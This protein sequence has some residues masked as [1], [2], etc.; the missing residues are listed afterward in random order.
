M[1]NHRV[2]LFC[3]KF[4][5]LD[6]K[7][8]K[9]TTLMVNRATFKDTSKKFRVKTRRK[10]LFNKIIRW[11]TGVPCNRERACFTDEHQQRDWYC[12]TS[13]QLWAF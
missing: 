2:I 11:D 1:I 10:L 13:I 7:K 8:F 12:C 4:Y 6:G 9:G 5:R 3:A